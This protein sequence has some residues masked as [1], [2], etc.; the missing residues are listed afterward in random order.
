[1]TSSMQ[2]QVESSN[3]AGRVES[4]A[5]REARRRALVAEA[6]AWWTVNE[7]MERRGRLGIGLCFEISELDRDGTVASVAVLNSMRARVRHHL[8][9]LTGDGG[10]TLVHISDIFGGCDWDTPRIVAAALLALECEDEAKALSRRASVRR[11]AK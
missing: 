10:G 4:P 2:G 3:S 9:P 6:K 8:A 5:E 11:E 1:M 7:R